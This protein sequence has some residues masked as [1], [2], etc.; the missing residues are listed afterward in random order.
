MK[1]RLPALLLALVLAFSLLP[2]TVFAATAVP[3]Q[4]EAYE[5]MIA[6]KS[7]YPE[8]MRWTNDNFYAWNGGIYSG[9][10]GCA[11]FAFMLSDAAFGDIPAKQFIYFDYSDVKVGDILRFNDGTYAAHS[12][13]VLEV[14]DDGVVIAEGNYASSVHWGR[15]LTKGQV[16]E[17]NYILTRYPSETLREY[18][19]TAADTEHGEVIAYVHGNRGYVGITPDPGYVFDEVTITNDTDGTRITNRHIYGADGFDFAMPRS[20]VTVTVTFKKSTRK[21]VV[22]PASKTVKVGE[23]AVFLVKEA[24]DSVPDADADKKVIGLTVHHNGD[25]EVEL[26]DYEYDGAETIV[27]AWAFKGVAEGTVSATFELMS[28]SGRGYFVKTEFTV[29]SATEKEPTEPVQPTEPKP[30]LP[31]KFNDVPA[32][33]YYTK[34]VAW[35]VDNG[36]AKGTSGKKFS[37]AQTCTEAQILTMLWRAE[38]K[39]AAEASPFTVASSYQKAVDWAYETGMIN[40]S[41]DPNASCTRARAVYFIWMARGSETATAKSFTDVDADAYYADAVSWAVAKKITK[42][43]SSTKFS[44][45]TPCERGMIVTFLYRAYK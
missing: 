45:D 34:A 41:F 9:G 18:K 7:A 37:P 33:E 27:G 31:T 32:G 1:K 15:T 21:F 13:I 12:V 28:E 5:A 6:L 16:M 29:V 2:G 40:D 22:E 11:G 30:E 10:Y 35:A 3:T 17:A 43:T 26:L 42:G 25:R 44:P 19:I 14:N 24:E 39:P 20:D 8:G 36:I 38:N 23:T 4:Q